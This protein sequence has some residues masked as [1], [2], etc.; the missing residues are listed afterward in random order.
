MP[1][2]NPAVVYNDYPRKA[3][4]NIV[5][6]TMPGWF[7]TA[8]GNGSI[9]VNGRIK[10][11]P[12]FVEEATTYIRI[13]ARVTTIKAGGTIEVRLFANNNG[14]PGALLSDYGTIALDVAASIE[15]VINEPLPRGYYWLA[16]RCP[17]AAS[18]GG[19]LRGLTTT[20][21][22]KSPMPGN[23]LALG[24]LPYNL[25]HVDAAWADPA[26]APT[27]PQSVAEAILWY[28]EN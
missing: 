2:S 20:D 23:A 10:Y 12:I 14:V 1:A 8:M 25:Y 6:W 16:Y 3:Q 22:F 24:S 28:R 4:P 5:R 27:N 11:Q 15:I 9:L 21:G 17:D 26:P 13:G 19:Q 18:A 7:A